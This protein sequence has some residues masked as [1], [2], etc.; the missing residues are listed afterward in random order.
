M[1]NTWK[2]GLPIEITSSSWACSSP[3]ESPQAQSTTS[4][5]LYEDP[6]MVARGYFEQLEQSSTGMH[7]YTGMMWKMKETP[8]GIRRPAPTLG[9]HNEYVFKELLGLSD[10]KYADLE[11]KGHVGTQYPA[12]LY[13]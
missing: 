2:N 1:T 6:Q 9:E 13:D 10:S 11:Q 3:R 4:A 5:I 7:P 8:N 12:H